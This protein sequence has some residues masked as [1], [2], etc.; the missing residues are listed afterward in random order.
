MRPPD[1]EHRSVPRGERSGRVVYHADR[2][3]AN[4]PRLARAQPDQRRPARGRAECRFWR[5]GEGSKPGPSDR[6]PA[7]RPAEHEGAGRFSSGHQ[8]LSQGHQP[9]DD[10]AAGRTGPGNQA[11]GRLRERPVDLRR[12]GPEEADQNPSRLAGGTVVQ[13]NLE[14]LHRIAGPG[15]IAGHHEIGGSRIRRWKRWRASPASRSWTAS[16]RPVNTRK[17]C[18]GPPIR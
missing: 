4:R 6:R 14:A 7:R 3:G 12:I 18:P 16:G 8:A 1:P 13:Q 15:V 11:Q 9:P 17:T 5:G 2:Q 10:P